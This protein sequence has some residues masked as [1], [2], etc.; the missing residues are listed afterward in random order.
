MAANRRAFS[1]SHPVV[2]TFLIFAIIAFMYAAS[3]FMKPLALAILLSF[4]LTPVARFLEKRGVPRVPGVILTVFI[5][6]SLIGFM[7]YNVANELNTLGNNV[8]Q[9]EDNI[10]AKLANLH[11]EQAGAIKKVQDTISNVSQTLASDPKIRDQQIQKVQLAKEPDFLAETESQLGPYLEGLETAFIVLILLLF[12]MINRESMSDRITQ[13]FGHGRISLTTRTTAEVGERISKYLTIFASMNTAMGIVVGVGCYFIGIE[14]YVLWGFLAG[15]LRFIPYAGPA[16]AFALPM[17]FSIAAYD[18]WHKPLM[19]VALYAVLEVAAN[20]VLEPIIYGKTTG[21]SSLALLVAAM[22]WSW[23]WGPIGLLLSTPLTVS[24]AVLGKYVP[25]LRFFATFLTEEIDLDP[26]VRFYQ[27]LLA[28]DQDGAMA[29]VDEQLKAKPRAEVFDEVVIPTLSLAE[30]DHA[31]DEIDEVQM[32]FIHRAIRV[33]MDDLGDEP[34]INLTTLAAPE[35][36]AAAPARPIKVLALPAADET[37][38]MV[39][40][41]LDLLT[42]P[43]GIDLEIGQ[44]DASPLAMADRVAGE[45]PDVVLISHLPPDGLTAARYLVRRLRARFPQLTIAVGRWDHDSEGE[46]AAAN[47]TKAGA[48]AVFNSLADARE[49]LVGRSRAEPAG[50]DRGVLAQAP[51]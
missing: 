15:A 21:V 40:Q 36:Q 2:I 39:L 13:L 30:R 47:L 4:A 10:K 9:Y 20:M 8:D 41:L 43:V 45:E 16:T 35:A 33:I 42:K 18:G 22:F 25:S 51:A 31:R 7:A 27:R 50:V 11:P 24:L 5:A 29:V 34:E 3:E 19:L 37:D 28:S 12:L 14:Y 38:G 17:L 23:L 26:S 48:T 6:L 49:Y 32:A 44:A 46:A 1:P